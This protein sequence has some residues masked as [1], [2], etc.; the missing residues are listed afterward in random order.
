[1]L[2]IRRGTAAKNYLHRLV[3]DSVYE[4]YLYKKATM[5]KMNQQQY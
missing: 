1:M 4:H 2:E 3:V 5:I